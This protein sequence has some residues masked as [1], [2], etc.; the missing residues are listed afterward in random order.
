MREAINN[1]KKEALTNESQANVIADVRSPV[2]L[3]ALD[4]APWVQR[5]RV[6]ALLVH[7]VRPII[8]GR[9]PLD[10]SPPS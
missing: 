9:S 6:P 4:T 3:S 5:I 10:L 2:E 7:H 8:P 1:D